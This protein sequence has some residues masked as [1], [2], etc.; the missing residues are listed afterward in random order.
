MERRLVR[1]AWWP[2]FSQYNHIVGQTDLSA[3]VLDWEPCRSLRGGEP[4]ERPSGLTPLPFGRW[5]LDLVLLTDEACLHGGLAVELAYE[6]DRVLRPGGAF[7]AVGSRGARVIE[8]LQSRL[9][10]ASPETLQIG[11]RAA[12]KSAGEEVVLLRRPRERRQGIQAKQCSGELERSFCLLPTF[13]E[14]SC[15]VD[16]LPPPKCPANPRRLTRDEL[17]F[18]ETHAK[19]ITS[20]AAGLRN[21]SYIACML[22]E[23]FADLAGSM[24]I[25]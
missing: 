7:A 20:T 3:Q 5:A 6:L 9:V 17:A 11:R 14:T 21:A 15:V 16:P 12:D 22:P 13:V 19:A 24:A 18:S 2:W 1:R 8:T 23:G 25:T 4:A 10:W